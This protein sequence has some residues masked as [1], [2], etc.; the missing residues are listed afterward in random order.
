MDNRI[1]IPTEYTCVS[2]IV[3]FITKTIDYRDLLIL[4]YIFS[5]AIFMQFDQPIICQLKDIIN[6]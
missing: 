1:K 6:S 5:F 2:P 4:I 3:S